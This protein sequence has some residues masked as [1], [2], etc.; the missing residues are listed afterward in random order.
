MM[1]QLKKHR[2]LELSVAS[3]VQKEIINI[4]NQLSK[5]LE[6][7]DKKYENDIKAIQDRIQIRNQANVKTEDIDARITLLENNIQTEQV[8]V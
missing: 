8:K 6:A 7:I 2:E 5:D 4:Q 3:R 1:K